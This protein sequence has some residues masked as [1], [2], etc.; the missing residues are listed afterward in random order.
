VRFRAIGSGDPRL[1]I[2]HVTGRDGANRAVAVAIGKPA[3]VESA[4]T[5]T[6][7]LPAMPNPMTLGTS[8]QYA[9]ATRGAIDLSIYSV[10][11]RRVATLAHGVQEAGRHRVAWN[12]T[13]DRGGVVKAGVYFVRFTAPNTQRSR[14]VTKLR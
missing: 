5:V 11:G 14:I 8:L 9:L 6:E 12:G 7:L 1:G 4:V 2:D 10:D 13:D 3:S